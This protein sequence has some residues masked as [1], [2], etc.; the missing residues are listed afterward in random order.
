MS[1]LAATAL[2]L[3]LALVVASATQGCGSSH[4]SGGPAPGNDIQL[5]PPNGSALPPASS[6]AQYSE[7]FTVLSGGT[8][9]YTFTAISIPPGL[10]F[11]PVTGSDTQALLSGKPSQVGNTV[12]SFQVVDSTNQKVTNAQYT[13]TVN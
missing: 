12:V 8:P 1:R 2:A 4:S 5:T 11:A 9:P 13:L 6:A 10:M 7:P 3:L